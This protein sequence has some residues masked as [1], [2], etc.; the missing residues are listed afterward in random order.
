MEKY[1]N[2][3]IIGLLIAILVIVIEN[4]KSKENYRR[5]SNTKKGDIAQINTEGRC[6]SGGYLKGSGCSKN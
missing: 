6:R 2:F 5:V 3:I 1:Y 4:K